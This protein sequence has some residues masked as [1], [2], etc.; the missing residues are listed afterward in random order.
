[1]AVVLTGREVVITQVPFNTKGLRRTS[2]CLRVQGVNCNKMMQRLLH[3]G[4]KACA[5][6]VCGVFWTKM[7]A[8]NQRDQLASHFCAQRKEGSTAL[9]PKALMTVLEHR[10]E[11]SYTYF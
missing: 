4:M 1:M 6:C 11:K 5:H 10:R 7:Q 8:E 3:P 9:R 2:R